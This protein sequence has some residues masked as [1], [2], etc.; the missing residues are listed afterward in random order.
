MGS[1]IKTWGNVSNEDQFWL[2]TKFRTTDPAKVV[3]A[4]DKLDKALSDKFP[5]QVI[6]HAISI[7]SKGGNTEFA[8]MPSAYD[9]LDDEIKEEL[10]GLICEHSQIFSRQQVGFTDFTDEEIDRFKPVRQTLIRK[11]PATGRKSL[12]LSSHAGRIDGLSVPDAKLLLL[13]LVNHATQQKFVYVH[14]WQ[15]GDLVMW[16]NRQT[17][18]RVRPFP[19]DEPRDMRR[20]TIVGDGPTVVEK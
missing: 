1:L 10:D 4:Q 7:P 11:H 3:A 9:A 16:D 17:M 18:H 5:G 14:E 2:L 12:Y 6:L 15:K 13:D 8:H 20:T 19:V